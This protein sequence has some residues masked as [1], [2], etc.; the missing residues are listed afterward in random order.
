MNIKNSQ[1][2]EKTPDP[3]IAKRALDEAKQRHV[4]AASNLQNKAKEIN[5]RKGLDPVRFG[6][7]EVKGIT[8]DF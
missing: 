5:G 1:K 3:D 4:E 2:N 7:W 8:S 6:D